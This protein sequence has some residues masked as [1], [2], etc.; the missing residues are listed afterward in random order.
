VEWLG[1]VAVAG[2]E[3]AVVGFVTGK[4]K[5]TELAHA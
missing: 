4:R 1:F 5:A 2:V 3:D